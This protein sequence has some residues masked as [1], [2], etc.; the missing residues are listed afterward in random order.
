MIAD[1]IQII[2][3]IVVVGCV[4]GGFLLDGGR[5]LFLWHPEEILMITGAAL[6]AFLT[7]NPPKV[8][9]R[10]VVGAWRCLKGPR[11]QR[12]DYVALLKVVYSILVKMR[13]AGG[14][15]VERELQEPNG[16]RLFSDYPPIV[17]DPQL[18]EFICDCLRLMIG[19]N[20]VGGSLDP[21]ELEMLL[22]QELEVRRQEVSEPAVA[23]QDV[24]DALPGFGIVAAVLGIVNTMGIL[25]ASADTVMIGQRVG[26]ALVGT[27]L[28]IVVSYG[29]VSPLA[30]AMTHS[31]KEEMRAFEVVKMALV[32]SVRGYAP[33]FAVEF[34]RKLLCSNDRPSFHDLEAAVKNRDGVRK[35]A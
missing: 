26:A 20:L 30:A 11:Y 6:G 28:G 8:T 34:A 9:R 10:A 7:S 22:E 33:V 29:F 25:Q 19:G 2:G 13:R 23:L 5:L 24:A 32:A 15:L 3:S 31:A 21:Q 16:G 1:V 18:L 17:A 12:D 4:I 14:T 27:F 35:A